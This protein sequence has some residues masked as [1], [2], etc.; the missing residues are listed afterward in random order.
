MQDLDT[1]IIIGSFSDEIAPKIFCEVNTIEKFMIK[2]LI[3]APTF[4]PLSVC[5]LLAF[6]MNL[7][8]LFNLGKGL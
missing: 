7:N 3:G 2:S 8:Y 1:R 5:P 4:F 6:V